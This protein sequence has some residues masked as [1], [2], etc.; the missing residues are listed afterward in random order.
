M[1]R[2]IGSSACIRIELVFSL[3]HVNRLFVIK[4]AKLN[5]NEEGKGASFFQMFIHDTPAAFYGQ[6]IKVTPDILEVCF[7]VSIL[8][9]RCVFG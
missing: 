6:A 8:R 9:S 7:Y 1:L 4:K 5:G 2:D 3:S